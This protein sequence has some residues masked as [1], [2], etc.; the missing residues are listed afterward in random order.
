[1][2]TGELAATRQADL[3]IAIKATMMPQW[4][5]KDLFWWLTRLRLMRVTTESRLG[6]RLSSR[7]DFVMG[8]SAEGTRTLFN[9][10]N[11]ADT[12]KLILLAVFVGSASWAAARNGALPRW[13]TW[14]GAVTVVFLVVGGLAFLAK[15]AVLNVALDISFAAAAAVGGSS[16]RQHAPAQTRAVAVSM[17]GAAIPRRPPPGPITQQLHDK[18]TDMAATVQTAAANPRAKEP[19]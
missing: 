11:K 14:L 16:E 2:I 18:E 12:I 8:S 10:I 15:S 9:A 1:V 5:G 17:R 7:P 19:R 6:R 4:L 3:S 13:V